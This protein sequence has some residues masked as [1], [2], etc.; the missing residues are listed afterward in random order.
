MADLGPVTLSQLQTLVMNHVKNHHDRERIKMASVWLSPLGTASGRK[1][2]K[3]LQS[4]TRLSHCTKV[5]GRVDA[6]FRRAGKFW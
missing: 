2:Y 3:P 1:I 4:R 5:F 6:K